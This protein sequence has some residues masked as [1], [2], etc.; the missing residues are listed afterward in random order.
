[1]TTALE[2][3]PTTSLMAKK[4]DSKNSGYAL[5]GNHNEKEWPEGE[6]I[7]SVPWPM[8]YVTHIRQTG[9]VLN[10]KAVINAARVFNAN[11]SK[12]TLMLLQK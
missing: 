7:F 9:N 12:S 8:D 1:M 11:R 2:V 3:K 4:S 5:I 6:G 10:A